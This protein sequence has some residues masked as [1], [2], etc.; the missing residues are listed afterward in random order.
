MAQEQATRYP[1]LLVPGLLGFVRLLVYPYWFGIV[2]ALERGGATV[3]PVMVSGVNSTEI[4]GEQL[5]KVIEQTVRETGVAKVNLIGHSQGALTVRYVAARR[6]DLVASVTSVAGPNYGSELADYLERHFPPGTLGGR[7][8]NAVIG[9]LAWTIVAFETGYRGPKLPMDITASHQS[10]TTTGVALFNRQYPQG[11]PEVW[12]EN[13][14]ELVDGVRYYS[15][16]GILKP[17]VTNRGR[18][19][20]DGTNVTC[21]IFARTFRKERGQSDGM[22]GRFSSHLGMV[23]G[24]DFPLDHFDIVNQTFGLVG[25]GADPVRLFMEHAARLKAAGL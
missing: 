18:N 25:K 4:R 11:L 9:L 17:G 24:D 16:S 8:V 1:L 22:V 21:R 12:G 14:E 2:K 23:I 3:I 10:L 20:I 15:W 13:G 5:L 19:L 7:V 6:P